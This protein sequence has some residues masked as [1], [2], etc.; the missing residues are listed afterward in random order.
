MKK[1]LDVENLYFSYDNIPVLENVS[2]NVREGHL[3]GLFGP[4]GSGKTTLFKCCLNLLPYD[5]GKI[6][7]N[8]EIVGGRK[9]GEMAKLVSYV[10]QE[11]SVP[12]PYKVKE[13]VLMGRTP[14]MGGFFGVS[15]R[16][17]DKVREV[18][19]L[20]DIIRLAERPYNQLSGGQRQLVL[21]A[22]ALAQ[23]TRVLFLDEPTAGLDF[24]NQLNVWTILKKITQHGKTVLACSHDPN[25][26]SWFCDSVVALTK[27][28]VVA[29]GTPG[30]VISRRL[31]ESM[32]GSVCNVG[33][34]NGVRMV[35]PEND[36][37]HKQ[38]E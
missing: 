26:I 34:I 36:F 23:E 33:S 31:L 22:R 7:I 28:G 24:S 18:M 27:E 4:N 30:E 37:M 10:P 9:V 13:V 35:Y 25:H 11:H 17:K 12:F 8:G 2:F 29:S 15:R 3:C 14:H 38:V 21:I 32:H 20:T 5:K 16:D 1:M 6:C 19:E